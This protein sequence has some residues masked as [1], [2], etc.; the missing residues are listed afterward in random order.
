MALRKD[1]YSK[2]RA[3]ARVMAEKYGIDPDIFVRQISVESGFN[4]KAV[5][6][7]GA[8]GIAQIVPKYHP[9][10][11]PTNPFESLE[12][13]AR[14]MS[15]LVKKYGS[16]E[17]ALSVYNSG[18]PTAYLD[19]NF[20]KG[21]TYNYVRKIMG[22]KGDKQKIPFWRKISRWVRMQ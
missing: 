10:V 8:I 16:Y 21:E 12:Y 2:Y 19:P 11:D 9:G 13:A 4:P 22:G 6:P 14:Y 5:S 17:K 20:A 3:Y 18:R 15:N 1:P 7:A